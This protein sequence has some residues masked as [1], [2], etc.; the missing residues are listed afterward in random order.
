MAGIAS[1]WALHVTF[2][3]TAATVPKFLEGW[4]PVY[5]KF[6]NEPDLLTFDVVHSTQEEGTIR[7]VET[8]KTDPEGIMKVIMSDYFKD[9]LAA[10]K[11]L[12]TK[13]IE[14]QFF[15]VFEDW[16]INKQ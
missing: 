9:F 13:P 10:N 11:T 14:V 15:K 12:V 3:L 8:W 7:F 16:K 2:P 4:R 5:A 6:Q 1:R